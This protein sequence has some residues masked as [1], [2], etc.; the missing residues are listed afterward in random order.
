MKNAV[1]NDYFC[2]KSPDMSIE[3]VLQTAIQLKFLNREEGNLLYTSATTPQLMFAAHEVR[4][5]LHPGNTVTWLIDRNVNYS[6]V[7][8]SGCRFCNFYRGKNH[9][10]AYITTPE[11]YKRKIDELFA[12]GGDQFLL[13]GGMH[14]DLGLAFYCDL[15]R[16]LKKIEPRL[17]LHA[18]GPP[19]VVHIAEMEGISYRETLEKLIEAGLDSLPGAGAEILVDRVRSLISKKKCTAGQWLDVMREAHKLGLTTSATMMFGHIETPEERIDHMLAVR[20]VQEERPAGATGFISFIP[21][22]F[23][24]EGTALKRQG[25]HN[26]ITSD[27]YIRT[28]ALSRLMLPNIPNIQASWLTVGKATGQLCLY[29][30]ANDF[31]SIMIEENVVSVAGAR[32]E[33]DKEGIQRAIREAGFIPQLRDQQFRER[34]LPEN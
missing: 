30:G 23:Q 9:R 12:L 8:I 6:N 25:I 26:S 24:D 33:F 17:K 1:L 13:Q 19:E 29:A 27:E 2:G 15:F 3:S 18:L 22:P 20:Q 14:P 4:K 5:K 31:G 7:C 32:N 21:W 11:E 10:E 16:N 28:L 34:I